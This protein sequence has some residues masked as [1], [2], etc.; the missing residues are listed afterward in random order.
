MQPMTPMIGRSGAAPHG[1][2]LRQPAENLLLGVVADAARVE[3][4]GIGVVDGV[5]DGVAVH[6]H[7]GGDHLGVGHVHLAAV[8][9]NE[10]LR[11][12]HW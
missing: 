5:G 3:Q 10:K 8:G 11:H 2:Q 9:L 7:D 6:L 12:G 1:A 4:H